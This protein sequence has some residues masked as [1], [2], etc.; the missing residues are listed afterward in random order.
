MARDSLPIVV[1]WP[2][3]TRP[4]WERLPGETPKAYA[5][6]EEYRDMAKMQRSQREVA[7]RLGKHYTQVRDWAGKFHWNRRIEAWDAHAEQ[8]RIATQEQAIVEMADR[9]A[10]SG[11]ALLTKAMQRLVGDPTADIEA[12]DPSSLSAADVA[13]LAEVGTKI[14]RLARG[15]D[16]QKDDSKPIEMKVKVAFDVEPVYPA[17]TLPSRDGVA[18]PPVIEQSPQQPQLPPPSDP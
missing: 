6:F 18:P 3:L 2:A 7:V 16:E 8:L 12:I 4:V 5:A 15:A 14:E 13:R 11:M 1:D 9:H 17:G 10:R